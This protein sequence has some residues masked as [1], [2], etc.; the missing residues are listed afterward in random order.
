[1]FLGAAAIGFSGLDDRS[2]VVLV[3]ALILIAGGIGRD[4][5]PGGKEARDRRPVAWPRLLLALAALGA[6][7]AIFGALDAP[8]W[9]VLIVFAAMGAAACTRPVDEWIHGGRPALE[10]NR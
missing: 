4:F 7:G 10:R 6:L 9:L 2:S 8:G 1:M 3:G 5:G